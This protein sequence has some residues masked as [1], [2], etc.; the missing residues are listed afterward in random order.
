MYELQVRKEKLINKLERE[1]YLTSPAVKRAMELVPREEFV[2]ENVRDAA[3][4]DRPLAIGFGQTIS[5]PHMNAMMCC[6][7]E[8]EGKDSKKVIEV[9]TGSGYHAALCAEILRLENS[10]GHVFTIERIRDLGVRARKVFEMLGYSDIITVVIED[11]S[12]GYPEE[13]PYDRILVT[14]AAPRIPESLKEQLAEGGIMMIPVGN[15]HGFQVLYKVRKISGKIKKE[16][17]CGVAFVPLVG[18][19]GFSST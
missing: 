5:A 1:G 4:A 14:A 17:I 8:L 16:R 3:Y 12:K 6:G 13:A 19:E 18:Q 15:R 10:D 2:P 7:L 9:G 11:G